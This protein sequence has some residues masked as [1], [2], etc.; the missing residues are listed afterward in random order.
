MVH[1]CL[2]EAAP[3]SSMWWQTR[4]MPC[5]APLKP[6]PHKQLFTRAAC[7]QLRMRVHVEGDR[8]QSM[9]YGDPAALHAHAC[10]GRACV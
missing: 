3:L 1:G 8:Q 4:S 2:L 5:M 7:L 9:L 10:M 6:K